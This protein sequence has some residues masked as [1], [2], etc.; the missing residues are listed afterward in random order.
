MWSLAAALLGSAIV[1]AEKHGW[2]RRLCLEAAEWQAT[3]GNL[4]SRESEV[5][6]RHRGR[7]EHSHSY[8]TRPHIHTFRCETKRLANARLALVKALQ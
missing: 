4:A 3:D 5:K 6:A 1:E 2:L 7:A 8:L